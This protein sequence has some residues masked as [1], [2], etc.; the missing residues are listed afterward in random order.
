MDFLLWRQL[1]QRTTAADADHTFSCLNDAGLQFNADSR[2]Y[3]PRPGRPHSPGGLAIFSSSE[4]KEESE[5]SDI[6]DMSD[7]CETSEMAL[8]EWLSALGERHGND[9]IGVFRDV[10]GLD[11]W[12]GRGIFR[13]VL[14]ALGGSSS[15]TDVVSFPGSS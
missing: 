1:R 15:S 12:L 4:S 6:C 14:R 13:A 11:W 7:V 9:L 8:R 3:P 10:D 5:A 2:L